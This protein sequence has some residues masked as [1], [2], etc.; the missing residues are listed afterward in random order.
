MKNKKC[1]SKMRKTR[2]AKISAIIDVQGV[3]WGAMAVRL[4]PKMMGVSLSYKE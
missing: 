3:K 2:K 4:S 1:R